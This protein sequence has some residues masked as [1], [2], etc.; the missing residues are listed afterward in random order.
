MSVRAR[1]G[2]RER[3]RARATAEPE[4][5]RC[6]WSKMPFSSRGCRGPGSLGRL[7]LPTLALRKI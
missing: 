2:E 5:F 1:E 3:G 4:S 7:S 6:S